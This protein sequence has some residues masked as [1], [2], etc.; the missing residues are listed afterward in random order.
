[1]LETFASWVMIAVTVYGSGLAGRR[2]INK[3]FGY[4]LQARGSVICTGL[5]LCTLYAE[6][7]SLFG[8]VN[9]AAVSVVSLILFLA[10][11]ISAAISFKEIKGKKAEQ[12]KSFAVAFVIVSAFVLYFALFAAGVAPRDWD[13]YN[14]HAQSIRWIEEYGAV[15]GLGNLHTRLAYNSAFLCLQALFSFSQVAGKSLHSLNGLLW[16]FGVIAS[17][18]GLKCIKEKKIF[19]SDIMRLLLIS[20][21]FRYECLFRISSPGTDLF[22]MIICAFIFISWAD[23]HE[24][25]EEDIR[26]YVLLAL[27]GM[28][29]VSVKLSALSVVLFTVLPAVKLIKDKKRSLFIKFALTDLLVILPYCIRSFIISGYLV[30]PVEV[31]ALNVSWRIP[32]F[33][34]ESDS[35]AIKLFARVGNDWKYEDAALDIFEWFPL[36]IKQESGFMAFMIIAALISSGVILAYSVINMLRKKYDGLC[37]LETVAAAGFFFLLF[38]APSVRFGVWW[39]MLIPVLVLYRLIKALRDRYTE[40]ADKLWLAVPVLMILCAVVNIVDYTVIELRSGNA[41]LFSITAQD[42]A[43][44]GACDASVKISGMDF[45]Y[46]DTGGSNIPNGYRGFPGS[47]TKDTLEKIELRGNDL[48]DGFKVKDEYKDTDY[49]FQGKIVDKR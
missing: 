32:A 45:Y 39:I 4:E 49:D 35:M 44:E 31:T 30:Y 13:S 6:T 5:V 38:T 2:L 48:R 47:E 9:G 36:W 34:A 43:D 46:P 25:K 23:L 21:L 26:P 29:A 42:Y 22:P 14:Y 17:V 1:M 18:T 3:I 16:A 11:A 12:D 41:G 27:F 24:K 10:S 8:G 15:L 7:C 19:L 37:F 20:V 33:T 40:K 28:F